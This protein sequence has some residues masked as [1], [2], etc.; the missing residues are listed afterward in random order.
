[1][2]STAGVLAAGLFVVAPAAALVGF[3]TPTGNI[4]CVVSV[5]SAR[6]DI[7]HHSWTP[8]PA[9]ASCDLDWGNAIAL[10]RRGKGGF[11]CAGDTA[12]GFP[13]RLDYGESVRR[14]RFRCT[15]LSTGVRCVNRRNGHGFRLSRESYRFF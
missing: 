13:R 10:D 5:T 9:P 2:L 3:H 7:R 8:P 1:V 11:I 6:C 4:G 12:L 15:S 14:G